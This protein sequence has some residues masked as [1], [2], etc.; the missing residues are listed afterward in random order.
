MPV[1]NGVILQESAPVS[2]ATRNF[3]PH[4]KASRA[5]AN[6]E[7]YPSRTQDRGYRKSIRDV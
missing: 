2:S 3:S 1:K 6:G 4:S 5:Y 7:C